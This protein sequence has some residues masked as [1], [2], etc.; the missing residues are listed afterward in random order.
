MVFRIV[1]E[2]VEGRVDL[3][4]V[5]PV[6]GA[7]DSLIELSNQLCRVLK[8]S[9]DSYEIILVDDGCPL[10]SWDVIRSIALSYND[11]LGI[12]LS[13]NFG[14][15]Y[16]ITAGIEHSS[17]RNIV[18]MDC[19][20]QDNPDD[21]PKLLNKA[22]EGFDVVL[23][24]RTSR[25]D[26][27][28]KLVSSYL[29][30]KFLSYMTDTKTN[31]KVGNYGLYS[32]KVVNAYLKIS[33][34]VRSFPLHVQWLGF[35]STFIEGIHNERHSG[36]SAYT[37]KK[38]LAVAT[39]VT[40]SFSDKPIKIMV[41]FGFFMSLI[42]FAMAIYYVIK[43]YFNEELIVGWATIVVSIWFLSGLIIMMLGIVGGYVARTFD[44]TKKR[45][46]YIVDELTS[47][48][49]DVKLLNDNFE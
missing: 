31:S 30:H 7:P 17:G 23:V 26:S 32:R 22:S 2:F 25:K 35:K 8:D 39:D 19:D 13:R 40:I 44:E 48:K 16:A 11:I 14:Q 24:H 29:F 12:R 42:S 15:H 9:V 5:V 41:K 37:L 27:I 49:S 46:V 33:E 10:G 36:V 38:L 3:S 43:W 45:P 21:I 20:L 6:Y 18:V 28:F 4:V 1:N 34:Q 47:E